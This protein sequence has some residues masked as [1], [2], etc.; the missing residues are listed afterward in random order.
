MLE[1]III[2]VLLVICFAINVIWAAECKKIND[3]W[4]EL[5]EKMNDDWANHCKE[6]TKQDEEG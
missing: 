4:K 5:C 3:E 2:A 1:R 6:I